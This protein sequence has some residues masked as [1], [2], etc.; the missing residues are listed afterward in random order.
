MKTPWTLV[1][2]KKSRMRFDWTTGSDHFQVLGFQPEGPSG[3][4][5]THRIPSAVSQFSPLMLLVVFA[6]ALSLHSF[7]SYFSTALQ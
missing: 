3:I 2:K 4:L 5:R 1:K 6:L 7:W